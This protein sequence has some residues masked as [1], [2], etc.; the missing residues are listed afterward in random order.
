V[1]IRFVTATLK[2]LDEAFEYYEYQLP[3]LGSRFIN[4]V[5]EAVKRI[6][7]MPKAWT[8]IGKWT[9]RCLITGFPYA[10]FYVCENSEVVVTA[11]ANLHRNPDHYR[12]KIT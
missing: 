2:E 12:D 11:L 1:K 3:G 4:E 9:R 8:R 7:F 5:N 6:I 10:L